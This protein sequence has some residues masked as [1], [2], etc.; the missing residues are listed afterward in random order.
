[1]KLS[2]R[3]VNEL[4]AAI[5]KGDYP[6]GARLPT[7][8]ELGDLLGVSRTVVR[9][10]LR[11]L[12]SMGLINVTQGR[13]TLVTVPDG[14]Q[15]RRAL[16]LRL[17]RSDLTMRDVIESR[18]VVESA[19]GREAADSGSDEDWD[20]MERFLEIFEQAVA[21]EQWGQA[22]AAH[23][24]FHVGILDALHAPALALT[25]QPLQELIL[26][27]SLTPDLGR[28]DLWEVDSHRP[29][30]DHL[31]AGDGEG[32]HCAL[33]RH[34]DYIDRPEYAEFAAT[35]FREAYALTS[36]GVIIG[37]YRDIA[38]ALDGDGQPL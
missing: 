9:D 36:F 32:T 35:L 5:V 14:S 15:V 29:I 33:R 37:E 10:A 2:D 25:L 16:A 6:A 27:S 23:L 24:R 30:L 11:T 20:R 4:Q 1:V 22:H 31:R 17:Q 26:I 13:G 19:L 12:A 28:V 8:P 3:V 21:N 7:E 34:F 18:V 38:Q